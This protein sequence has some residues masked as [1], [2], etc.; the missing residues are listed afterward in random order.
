MIHGNIGN[1][2]YNVLDEME[3]SEF[4][5]FL[6]GSRF[7][8]GHRSDSDY[9]FFVDNASI[10]GKRV[11]LFLSK[12]GF[13]T[14]EYPLYKD[15]Q[16]VEVYKHKHFPIHIQ[17]TEDATLKK[18]IQNTIDKAQLQNTWAQEYL[19]SAS[20]ADKT[21]FWNFITK[22]HQTLTDCPDLYSRV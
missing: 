14:Q 5:F 1:N 21:N 4:D 17:I 12:L 15:E 9:D 11:E 7:F 18:D 13:N 8:G 3:K 22:Y 2:L 19:R 16:T 10:D 20:P 6:T